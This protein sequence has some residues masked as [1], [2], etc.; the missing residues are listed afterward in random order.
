MQ[1]VIDID[2]HRHCDRCGT[3]LTREN[4][5]CGYEIC[6]KCNEYLDNLV[7]NKPRE[8]EDKE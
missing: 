4:N 1:M 5:K 3:I 7:K 6:D 8:S 2:G